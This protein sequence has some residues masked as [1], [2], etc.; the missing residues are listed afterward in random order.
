MPGSHWCCRTGAWWCSCS[1]RRRWPATRLVEPL[2][3]NFQHCWDHRYLSLKQ[4]LPSWTRWLSIAPLSCLTIV[5]VKVFL[6]LLHFKNLHEASVKSATF[7]SWQ[8]K[9]YS[10]LDGWTRLTYRYK[11]HTA[12]IGWKV[13]WSSCPICF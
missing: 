5:V 4:N 1:E 6:V 3:E 13:E 12:Y 9:V 2:K 8:R 11:L 10:S 7:V